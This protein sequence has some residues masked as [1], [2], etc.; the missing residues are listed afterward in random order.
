MSR[1]LLGDELGFNILAGAGRHVVII[2]GLW[3]ECSCGERTKSTELLTDEQLHETAEN[4]RG[5][6]ARAMAAELLALRAY[7]L[8][9]DKEVAALRARVAKLEAAL[10]YYDGPLSLDGGKRARAALKDTPQ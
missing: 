2:V 3:F 8:N 4:A 10:T 9:R 1:H 5:D 6:V 7:E